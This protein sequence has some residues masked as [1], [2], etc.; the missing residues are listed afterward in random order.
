MG[1]L[2]LTMFAI[3]AAMVVGC[4]SEP[5]EQKKDALSSDVKGTLL[6]MK[7]EDPSFGPFLDRT[8]AY[9]V[10]PAVGKG[11][12]IVGGAYGR[13]EVWEKG[14]LIG[15]ADITQATIGAQVG[16]QSFA[17]VIC[18]RNQ[19]ALD[20]FKAGQYE[21]T[22]NASAV[23]IKSGAG[24]TADYNNDVAI[25]TYEKGGLMAEAS[26]GGQ[27]FSFTPLNRS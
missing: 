15:Y 27:R 8:Y 5:E 3:F 25:F 10:F 24:A 7:A 18:F 11:G 9:V 6:S 21:P 13:G 14:N 4:A 19:T 23:A 16:G 20:K 26:V 2:N 22:A 1:R 12:L 17:E